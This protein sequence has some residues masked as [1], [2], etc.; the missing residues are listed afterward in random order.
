MD[1]EDQT[2][3]HKKFGAPMDAL[4]DKMPERSAEE[5][6][7]FDEMGGFLETTALLVDA[8]ESQADILQNFSSA[9][10]I[11]RALAETHPDIAKEIKIALEN[12]T[13][14]VICATNE[15]ACQQIERESRTGRAIFEANQAR[16]SLEQLAT[17]IARELWSA[18]HDHE[19][20][21]GDTAKVVVAEITRQGY[22][23]P[24]LETVKGWIRPEAPEYATKGGRPKKN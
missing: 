22:S 20:R 23:P 10:G 8:P 6:F 1:F 21:I 16:Q 11:L 24:T 2:R 4:I 19:Y 12:L 15:V 5:G 17:G 9:V 3:T 13:L 18:D 14:G 7:T